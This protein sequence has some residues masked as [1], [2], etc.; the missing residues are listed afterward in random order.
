[1]YFETFDAF[2]EM[3]GHGF[4]IWSCYLI[5]S[6]AMVGYYYVSAKSAVKVKTKLK[7]FYAKIDTQK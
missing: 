5:A 2:L 6:V 1:M 3:G 4:Y 7:S